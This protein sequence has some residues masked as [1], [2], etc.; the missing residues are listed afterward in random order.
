LRHSMPSWC[1]LRFFFAFEQQ[2]LRL[3]C[4]SSFSKV[5]R[6]TRWMTWSS[7]LRL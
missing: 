6:A 7:S 3:I 2:T 5:A 4:W 1:L